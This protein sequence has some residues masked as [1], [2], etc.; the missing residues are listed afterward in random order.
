MSDETALSPLRRRFSLGD[1]MIAIAALA[2]TF[3]L[4][5][6]MVLSGSSN[7]LTSLDA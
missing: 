1:G 4:A 2:P 5:T 7:R 3:A 6:F